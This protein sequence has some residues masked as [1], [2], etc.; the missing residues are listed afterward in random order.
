MMDNK[1]SDIV[2]SSRIRLARNI[3]DIPFPRKLEGQEE[4]YSKLYKG[5]EKACNNLFKYDFYKMDNIDN[6][7]AQQLKEQHLISDNLIKSKYGAAYI[8]N[9]KDISIMANEEDHLR[10][11]CIH[12]G[13]DLDG[14]YNQIV[15]VDSELAKNLNYAF[16]P[17]LGYL[18]SCPTNLG[19][20]MRASVMIFLPALTMIGKIDAFINK[21]QTVDGITTRGVYG[22]GSKAEGYMYQISNQSAI[23]L[24][25]NEILKKM[26]LVVTK[27]CQAEIEAR[28]I[29]KEKRG[30]DL[31]DDIMRAYG[32]LKYAVKMSSNETNVNIA[33]VKLGV[34]LG[35]IDCDI[36]KLNR[37]LV[38]TQPAMV[39]S[40]FDNKIISADKRDKARAEI[41]KK[42]L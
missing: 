28:Q 34:S 15:K 35:Y 22:E 3:V 2:I 26:T 13:F 30:I 33:M 11:Q 1:Y 24:S 19:T 27:L 6:L 7:T 39:C 36:D 16:D 18:T 25:E 10:I 8:S 17:R 31:Q 14:A 12:S 29:L 37:L 40:M 5:I 9:T 42:L 38:L 4:I 32:I 20:A 21:F 41:I 23:S